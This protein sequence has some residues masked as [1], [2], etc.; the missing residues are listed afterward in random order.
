MK[1]DF[2]EQFQDNVTRGP[3][4]N[5]FT[6]ISG[7]ARE[8]LTYQEVSDEIKIISKYLQEQGIKPKDRVAIIMKNHAR[9]G[10]AALAVQSI[11]AI[12]VPLDIML[13]A[14]TL[15][16]QL[17]HSG[18]CY[19]ITS[20]SISD[21]A[22]DLLERSEN[23]IPFLVDGKSDLAGAEWNTILEAGDPTG[24]P[25]PLVSRDPEEAC[26]IMYTSGTTGSPKG[27]VLNG[28]CLTLNSCGTLDR[29]NVTEHDHFLCVLPLYHILAY[30]FFFYAPLYRGC[31]VTFLDTLEARQVLKTF[32]EEG[33]TVFVCV[34]QFYNLLLQ[35]I[36]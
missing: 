4:R 36:M 19:C 7:D 24:I 28:Q 26:I 16:Y 5:A 30:V 10:I 17:S 20:S 3:H 2:F 18:C 8:T 33:I 21:L 12:I 15:A 22:R 14:D 6:S 34:P 29:E 13:D 1:S 23:P 31:R 32:K 27:V 35:R 25:T 11:G 9:W